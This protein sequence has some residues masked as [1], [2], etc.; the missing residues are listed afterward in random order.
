[1]EQLCRARPAFSKPP[2][3]YGDVEV[4]GLIKCI[5]VKVGRVTPL[6]A[7]ESDIGL[8]CAQ[9]GERQPRYFY[10]TVHSAQDS[11]KS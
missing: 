11:P 10:W 7:G 2:D 8:S 4:K 3:L 1:M 5:A 6:R 9:K